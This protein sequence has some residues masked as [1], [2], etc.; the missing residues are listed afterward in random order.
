M[1]KV[2]TFNTATPNEVSNILEAHD[3]PHVVQEN[4]G[5]ITSLSSGKLLVLRECDVIFAR[6]VAN[7][8]IEP[9]G[10][11]EAEDDYFEWNGVQ[12]GGYEKLEASIQEFVERST[13][14]LKKFTLYNVQRRVQ[15]ALNKLENAS[16]TNM[17]QEGPV[18]GVDNY[19]DEN[20]LV[21][22][23]AGP[24]DHWFNGSIFITDGE[25]FYGGHDNRKF[26]TQI[27]EMFGNGVMLAKWLNA[28]G[29]VVA[30]SEAA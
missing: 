24:Y 9:V 5:F 1:I 26:N 14:G 11:D 15:A 16:G 19:C 4:R 17:F 2:A 22:N 25:I 10:F 28:S 12:D 23:V 3:I 21:L 30:L 8:L 29:S 6:S 13:K 27:D 20:Q 18:C 7:D